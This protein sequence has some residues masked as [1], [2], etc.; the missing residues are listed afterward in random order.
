MK[1]RMK[2]PKL[3]RF[4]SLVL[5]TSCSTLKVTD[6]DQG[7]APQDQFEREAAA[8]EMEASRSQSMDGMG[9]LAGITSYY[10]SYDRVFDPCMRSK[11]YKKK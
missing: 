9:G 4:F 1:Q 7:A 11:G 2:I 3:F 5:L 6:Y 10:E 8:C